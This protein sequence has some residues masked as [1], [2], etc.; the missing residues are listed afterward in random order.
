MIKL[1]KIRISWSQFPATRF[2]LTNPL[3]FLCYRSI[4][5]NGTTVFRVNGL[6]GTISGWNLWNS[7]PC[8]NYLVDP[9]RQCSVELPFNRTS[10]LPSRR[11]GIGFRANPLLFCLINF[12]K[13]VTKI[14][15]IPN[16]V[17][18][19]HSSDQDQSFWRLDQNQTKVIKKGWA[20]SCA[21]VWLEYRLS[22]TCK[23]TPSFPLDTFH[24][25]YKA[26]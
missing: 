21:G 24:L 1:S 5:F 18:H 15:L 4:I 10:T 12:D 7:F 19:P 17:V 6:P 9:S 26:V 22:L 8:T 25:F 13:G 3:T 11:T 16:F 20:F 2:F 23:D 14:L